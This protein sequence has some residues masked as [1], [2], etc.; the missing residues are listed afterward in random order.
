MRNSKILFYSSSEA[1]KHISEIYSDPYVWW[2]SQQVLE[3]RK[4][5]FETCGNGEGNWLKKWS[6]FL[7]DNNAT[8]K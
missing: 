2:N 7:L 6:D 8:D 1:A 5:F 4:M 3:T